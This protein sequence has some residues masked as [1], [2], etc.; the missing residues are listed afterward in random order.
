MDSPDTPRVKCLL[1]GFIEACVLGEEE[2]T[3]VTLPKDD[4]DS[5]RWIAYRE[6]ELPFVPQRGLRLHFGKHPHP[7]A[8]AEVC[9][10]RRVAW[11]PHLNR[12]LVHANLG[13]M[14]HIGSTVASLQADWEG[15]TV[16]DLDSEQFDEDGNFVPPTLP[17][18]T[19]AK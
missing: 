4:E 5:I 10:I 19:Q 11:Q 13:I 16:E 6:I 12:W 2:G 1:W 17:D 7:L 3:I 18:D 14:A 15:W 9:R 8:E